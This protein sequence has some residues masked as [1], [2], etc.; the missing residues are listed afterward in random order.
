MKS[1]VKQLIG[2]PT[3]ENPALAWYEKDLDDFNIIENDGEQER[4][5]EVEEGKGE[6]NGDLVIK[7]DI[8]KTKKVP[9]AVVENGRVSYPLDLWFML[10]EFIDP[11]DIGRFACICTSS[12]YV[13]HTAQFWKRLYDRHYDSSLKL[14]PQLERTSMER[15]QGLRARVIRALQV[16][17]PPF[18]ERY[19]ALGQPFE[20]DIYGVEGYRCTAM[21]YK[22]IKNYW[23]FCFRLKRATSQCDLLAQI[24]KNG[25]QNSPGR[26]LNRHDL[27]NGF[28]NIHDNQEEGCCIMK[29]TCKDYVSFPVIMGMV[30]NKVYLNVSQ[31]MRF[32]RLRLVFDTH[33]V[34]DIKQCCTGTTV[35]LD[36]V[37]NAK[38]LQ[39]WDP[40]FPTS[41]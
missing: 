5:E 28:N 24:S 15:L 1:E 17:H 21:W 19:R 12:H 3:Q 10:S 7:P 38:I 33:R 25:N 34:K 36:P 35:V 27:I 32:H 37:L 22:K 26:G 23:N 6:T 29:V 40:H 14:P 16:M 13:I 8:K 18:I 31:N 2:C 11:R 30:L 39:W 20:D 9:K 4:E 41:E